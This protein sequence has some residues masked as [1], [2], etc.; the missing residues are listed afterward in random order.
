MEYQIKRLLFDDGIESL[1]KVVDLQSIVYA[2]SNHEFS[3][4]GFKHL[5]VDNP[6]GRVIS[7]NAFHGNDSCRSL[8]L[9]PYKNEYRG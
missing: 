5:Y 3:V 8:R 1:Q 9:Y 6:S 7:F 2:G 4:D